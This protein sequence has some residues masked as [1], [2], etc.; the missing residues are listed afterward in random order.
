[1]RAPPLTLLVICSLVGGTVGNGLLPLLPLY[2]LG[3]GLAQVALGAYLAGSYPAL[4]AGALLAGWLADM[5]RRRKLLLL[6]A[7]A[8][9]MPGLW[10]LGQASVLGPAR[11]AAAVPPAVATRTV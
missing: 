8:L 2:A 7:G 9:N 4:A 6:L 5:T 11:R 1:M 10:L 3:F